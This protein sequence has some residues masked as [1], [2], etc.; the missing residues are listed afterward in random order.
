MVLDVVWVHVDHLE[1]FLPVRG[2]GLQRWVL[3]RLRRCLFI[4]HG[5]GG[6]ALLLDGV[7]DRYIVGKI[8]AVWHGGRI[9]RVPRAETVHYPQ[10]E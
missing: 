4:A 6:V 9:P 7:G 1:L 8:F 5:F 2:G 3:R 10:C